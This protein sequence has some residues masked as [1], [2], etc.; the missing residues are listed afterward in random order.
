MSDGAFHYEQ[1]LL[2]NE[3]VAVEPFNVRSLLSPFIQDEL[4]LEI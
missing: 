2:E 3:L 4:G 1:K